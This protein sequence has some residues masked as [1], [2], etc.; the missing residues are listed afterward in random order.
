[1]EALLAAIAGSSLAVLSWATLTELEKL[2]I[3]E[4][5]R[6]M[7]KTVIRIDESQ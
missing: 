5:R 6:P 4:A 7:S 2:A 1:L 3:E